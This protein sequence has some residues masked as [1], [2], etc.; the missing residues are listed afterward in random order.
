V[1]TFCLLLFWIA[2]IVFPMSLAGDR[3]VVLARQGFVEKHLKDEVCIPN[4]AAGVSI[5]G[6]A[7]NVE[8]RRECREELAA[9]LYDLKRWLPVF[10]GLP[11]NRNIWDEVFFVSDAASRPQECGLIFHFP[12][13]FIG[14]GRWFDTNVGIK[15][16]SLEPARSFSVILERPR[17]LKQQLLTFINGDL[18]VPLK[19]EVIDLNDRAFRADLRVNGFSSCFGSDKGFIERSHQKEGAPRGEGSDHHGPMRHSSL[20]GI[21]GERNA[22]AGVIAALGFLISGF[23]LIALIDATWTERNL[24]IRIACYATASLAGPLGFGFALYLTSG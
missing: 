4:K 6:K 21:I 16:Y 20:L 12:F 11:L 13:R 14:K 18:S 19:G 22:V 24:A 23:F 2:I 15:T 17:K 7:V 3:L 9:R 5:F 1:K 8:T 10:Q